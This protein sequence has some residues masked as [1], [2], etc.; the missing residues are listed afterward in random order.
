ME[1][2]DLIDLAGSHSEIV[3]AE[4]EWVPPSTGPYAILTSGRDDDVCLGAAV[5]SE[6]AP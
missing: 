5:Y 3:N 1:D 2:E 6:C 4:I